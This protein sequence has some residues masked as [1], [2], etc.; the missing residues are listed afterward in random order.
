MQVT[1]HRAIDMVRDLDHA[2]EAVILTGADR[3][4]TSGAAQTAL[5]GMQPVAALVSAAAGRIGIM[6]GG[7]V[8]PENLMEIARG[9]GASEFHAALR[10]LLPSSV[11]YRKE[12]LSLGDLAIDAYDRQGVLVGDV[13]D[14]RSVMDK[15][16]LNEVLDRR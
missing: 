7:G 1:F 5:L 3:I 2:L 14:L 15:L 13:R 4:L 11:T 6:V 9:T 12:G 16:L 10:T 8:R